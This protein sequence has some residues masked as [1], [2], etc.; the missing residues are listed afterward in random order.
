[1]LPQIDDW[2]SDRSTNGSSGSDG[3]RLLFHRVAIPVAPLFP[4]VLSARNA[5]PRRKTLSALAVL[6]ILGAVA[7]GLGTPWLEPRCNG[8]H[9][10][11]R[12]ETHHY[13]SCAHDLSV[14]RQGQ[15]LFGPISKRTPKPTGQRLY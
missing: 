13:T 10:R 4:A 1:M 3:G 2:N 9:K 8:R 5:S 12:N 15:V 7:L 11:G 14:S 6:S